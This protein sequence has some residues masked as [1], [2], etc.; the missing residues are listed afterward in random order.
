MTPRMPSRSRILLIPA[1]LLLGGCAAPKWQASK[2]LR[3]RDYA[4]AA[5]IGDLGH[6]SREQLDA[7]A[8]P[9]I[10]VPRGLS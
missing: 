2:E 9:D 3:A 1:M 6:G 8:V 4:V 10:E 5:A 7:S